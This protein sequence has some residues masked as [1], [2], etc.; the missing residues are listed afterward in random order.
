MTQAAKS[1]YGVMLGRH[2]GRAADCLA[3]GFIAPTSA[4]SKT[5]A[6]SCPTRGG[7]S[8]RDTSDQQGT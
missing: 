8:G 5:L 2:S 4:S 7:G 3:G 1:Y 6:A